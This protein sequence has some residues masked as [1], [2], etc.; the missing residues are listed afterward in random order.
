M[1][2]VIVMIALAVV[3]VSAWV[4]VRGFALLRLTPAS[5]GRT[6]AYC[7]TGRGIFLPCASVEADT[8]TT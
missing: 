2:G 6:R 7:D 1:R 3:L 5:V 4:G 8:G